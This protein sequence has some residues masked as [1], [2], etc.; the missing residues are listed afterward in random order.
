M[1]F[2]RAAVFLLSTASAAVAGS[3]D[4]PFT[5]EPGG[6]VRVQVSKLTPA[7]IEQLRVAHG[8]KQGECMVKQIAE[9]GDRSAEYDML[10]TK[11]IHFVKRG[12][13][14]P[15]T[16]CGVLAVIRYDANGKIE[17]VVEFDK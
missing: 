8:T 15:R 13:S 9:I 4:I 12:E 11:G 2:I 16:V 6:G 1:K 3:T 14:R 7:H 10:F 17:S 5:S